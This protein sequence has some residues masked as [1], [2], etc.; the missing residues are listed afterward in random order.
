MLKRFVLLMTLALSVFE[1]QSQITPFTINLDTSTTRTLDSALLYVKN[2]SNKII[3][4]TQVNRT[5][6]QFFTRVNSFTINPLDSFPVWIIFSSH[7]NLTYRS[8][9][10]FE[11][12]SPSGGVK[13]S[14]V[15][16]AVATAKYPDALYFFTQGLI[17]ENLK[18]ALKTFTT[19]GYITLG[20]NAARDRMFETIDDYGGDTIECVYTGRKVYATNRT[21][22]QNQNFNTEHT[23]PQSFFNSNDPMV[24]DIHHLFPTD[25][26]A[27]SMRA[28]YPFGI[29]VSGITWQVGGSKLGR[30]I[31]N[32]IVFEPRDIHK[33]NC[34]RAIF[35]FVI[36][37]QNWG[38]YLAVNQETALRQFHLIDT[39]DARE[40][41]RNE[42]VK[43][44]Q[45]NRN[46]FADHP[47]FVERVR[48]FYQTSPTP[49]KPEITASPFTVRFDTVAN[50][51]DTTSYYVSIFNYGNADLTLS[52]LTSNNG[53][54]TVVNYPTTIPANQYGLA[55]I[56]FTPNIT[57]QTY[58]GELTINNN[59][60]TIK[61]NL[62][63]ICGSSIGIEP[64]SNEIPN[65][66][67]LSQNFPNPF[68]PTTK[69]RF[70]IS[71][72][73]RPIGHPSPVRRGEGGEVKLTVFD[74]LGK[75]VATLVNQHLQ[76]GVY[77]INFDGANFTSGVYF[78]KLISDSFTETK[79]MI[80]LK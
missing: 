46:P 37:H 40:R 43:T 72:S 30:D 29:V 56:R 19:T 34:A 60:S 35:Y 28:N 31:Y 27:N 2:P 8:F 63:G 80:I 3:N 59:D 48:A 71:T 22:A 7:Q 5:A 58:N 57:N 45:N 25:E 42:R 79:R 33:G 52:S 4:V 53:V 17:D 68:N 74:V 47:E 14:L 61:V 50:A 76:P 41:L 11:N 23:W 65:E 18:A 69:I 55:R 32:S 67:G 39:V 62:I 49:I 26:T 54:F 75:E 9:L 1:V 16:S 36:R 70:Q 24:S 15:Y 51:F 10:I 6:S 64:I 78:Y 21:E 77:E 20:Y 38:S 73:P 66:F 12:T 13:Q 44:F